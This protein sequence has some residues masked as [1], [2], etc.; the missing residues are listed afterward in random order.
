VAFVAWNVAHLPPPTS[1]DGGFPA[2]AEAATRIQAATDERAIAIRSLPSFK[3][4]DTYA[5]PLTRDGVRIVPEDETRTLVI[6]CDALFETAIGAPCGGSA[7]EAMLRADPFPAK[8]DGGAGQAPVMRDRFEAAPG[9]FV[10]VYV[11]P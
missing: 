8:G 2:A 9:R 1:P 7:E 10:T 3:S 5:Y 6:V 4:A 11:Q